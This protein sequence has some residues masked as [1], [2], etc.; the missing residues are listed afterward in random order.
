M[1]VELCP[2]SGDSFILPSIVL[3]WCSKAVSLFPCFHKATIN[4]ILVS[5]KDPE[6]VLDYIRVGKREENVKQ[7]EGRCI[8]TH[9]FFFFNII[10]RGWDVFVCVWCGGMCVWREKEPMAEHYPLWTTGELLGLGNVSTIPPE[11]NSHSYRL[12]WWSC[13]RYHHTYTTFQESFLK[14]TF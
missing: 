11:L 7:R 3:P 14:N 10:W 8:K 1:P 5:V 2:H 12:M 13:L 4:T 9:W 6:M